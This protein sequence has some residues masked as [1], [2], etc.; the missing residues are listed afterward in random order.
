M[1]ITLQGLRATGFHG[2]LAHEQQA[3]Q[4]FIVDVTFSLPPPIGDALSNTVDYSAVANEVIALITGPPF[5]LIETLA[6]RIADDILDKWPIV[7]RVSVTVHKPQ[8]PLTVPFDDVY[9]HYVGR[10]QIKANHRFTLSLGANLGDRQ[11]ALQ[12]AVDALNHTAGICVDAVSSVYRTAPVEV[13]N[14][15]PDYYNIV[16][17]GTTT[18]D[19][20]RL[21][22]QT[23]A[24][25]ASFGRER[26]SWHAAR[27]LDIDLIDY[28]NLSLDLPHPRAFERGF[29]LVPW[30]EIAPNA[31]LPQGRIADLS[32]A[33]D[34]AEITRIGPLT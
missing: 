32:A 12:G 31:F 24:I 26:P 3:G 8:A 33:I 1:K 6:S 2:V 14:D 23:Q 7:S 13:E 18:L 20:A 15:Q 34:Q 21:L 10:R 4:P 27:T 28:D 9:C 29:V 5:Q 16:V 11:A 25:E 22:A 17:T 19:P 30:A